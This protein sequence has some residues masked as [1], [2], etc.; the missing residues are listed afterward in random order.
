MFLNELFVIWEIMSKLC[1]YKRHWW[2]TWS[3]Q[4][5]LII[6]R[7]RQLEKFKVTQKIAINNSYKLT[8]IVVNRVNILQYT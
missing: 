8:R 5:K 7:I 4:H 6:L 2:D 1:H 3:I